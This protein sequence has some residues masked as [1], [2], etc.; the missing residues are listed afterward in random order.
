MT[1][2]TMSGLDRL[3]LHLKKMEQSPRPGFLEPRG[4]RCRFF[5]WIKQSPSHEVLKPWERAIAV[6][7]WPKSIC[8]ILSYLVYDVM[9]DTVIINNVRFCLS[10]F[11]R[12][13]KGDP[14]RWYRYSMDDPCTITKIRHLICEV[15]FFKHSA[16]IKWPD[17]TAEAYDDHSLNFYRRG[18]SGHQYWTGKHWDTMPPK[19]SMP[20][21]HLVIRNMETPHDERASRATL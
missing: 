10:D 4:I 17:D 14:D 8:Y 2:D 13:T 21:N 3:R 11:V 19:C 1:N 15:R 7:L 6:I 18:R 9:S 12:M 16:G 20:L 5:E